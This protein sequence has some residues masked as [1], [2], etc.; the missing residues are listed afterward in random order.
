MVFSLWHL[1]SCFLNN[2]HIRCHT[3]RIN[4][5]APVL[6]HPPGGYGAVH[7]TCSFLWKNKFQRPGMVAWDTVQGKSTFAVRVIHQ[8]KIYGWFK[9]I[10][11]SEPENR[12]MPQIAFLI[13]G[14]FH[15]QT[16]FTGQYFIKKGSI[17]PLIFHLLHVHV[18]W[19]QYCIS[20]SNCCHPLHTFV[21]NTDIRLIPG[22]RFFTK[23]KTSFLVVL[24]NM[25]SRSS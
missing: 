12:S 16:S 4:P 11:G 8:H 13:F 17:F 6:C 1:I 5:P 19:T 20:M 10:P 23:Y 21:K 18:T 25:F 22:L 2:L 14:Q 3:F 15:A 9:G 24:Y 7:R